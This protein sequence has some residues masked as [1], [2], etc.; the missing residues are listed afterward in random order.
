MTPQDLQRLRAA[1]RT[2]VTDAARRLQWAQD[3]PR[4]DGRTWRRHM[5][6]LQSA[7][8]LTRAADASDD[9]LRHNDK[10]SHARHH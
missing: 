10:A 8:A 6:I 5:A 3:L 2:L 1:V 7:V 4:A 9:T